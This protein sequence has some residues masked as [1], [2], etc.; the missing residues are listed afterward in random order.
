MLTV[1][2]DAL[3]EDCVRILTCNL[4]SHMHKIVSFEIFVH[5]TSVLIYLKKKLY[6]ESELNSFNTLQEI[7]HTLQINV[8][9]FYIT[10]NSRL[11]C[12]IQKIVE[13]PL[14]MLHYLCINMHTYSYN[15]EQYK[16]NLLMRDK[17]LD[18]D[19]IAVSVA[20][21]VLD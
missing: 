2:P 10:S 18:M 17:E 19:H 11:N 7:L 12:Y 15:L 16:Y 14:A 5:N 4:Y 20:N 8:H 21:Y 1:V 3:K 6:I 9:F 13:K